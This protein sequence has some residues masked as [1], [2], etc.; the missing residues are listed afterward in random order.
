VGGVAGSDILGAR[1]DPNEFAAIR[2][3]LAAAETIATVRRDWQTITQALA[4][5]RYA[6]LGAGR[7]AAGYG[8]ARV[9]ATARVS[10]RWVSRGNRQRIAF[11][12]PVAMVVTR[13][14]IRIEVAILP[15]RRVVLAR[16]AAVVRILRVVARARAIRVVR[17]D[18]AIPV[19]VDAVA[20]LIDVALARSHVTRVRDASVAS[21]ARHGRRPARVQVQAST[22]A[23]AD[24]RDHGAGCTD[25][26][27]EIPPDFDVLSAICSKQTQAEAQCERKR[28]TFRHCSSLSLR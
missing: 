22:A 24:G 1:T 7:T 16:Y 4:R 25:A 3:E 21:S 9:V 19:I 17:I 28:A 5:L 2:W 12:I 26:H 11:L 23:H 8:R 18:Q 6:Q 10:A 13:S 27:R 20:A 15:T 14:G